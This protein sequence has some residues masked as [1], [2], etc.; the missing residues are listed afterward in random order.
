MI[1]PTAEPRASLLQNTAI[2]QFIKYCIVGCCNFALDFSIVLVLAYEFDLLLP[3]ATTISFVVAVSNSFYWN[4]RWTF[5]ALYP[6]QKK[7]QYVMFVAI[8]VVG[9]LLR[10]GIVTFVSWV[11]TGHSAEKNPPKAV[12]ATATLIATVV[13]VFWNFLANKRWTFKQQ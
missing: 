6:D 12:A 3:I 9:L 11:L 13:V 10:L 8:N 2:R 1:E 4:S 5:K 7:R